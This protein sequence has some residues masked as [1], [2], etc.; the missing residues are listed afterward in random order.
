M[1]QRIKETAVTG[2][3]EFRVMKQ[4]IPA[5]STDHARIKM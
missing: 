5:P 2:L 4:S 1:I 3:V